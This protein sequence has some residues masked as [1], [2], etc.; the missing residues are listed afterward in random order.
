MPLHLDGKSKPGPLSIDWQRVALAHEKR[1][2]ELEAALR[3][4]ADV[5]REMRERGLD[6][7]DGN[8]INADVETAA[9]LAA[10]RLTK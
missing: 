3:P 2:A 9:Y 8:Y 6:P 4:F 7:A 5:L 1:I 10:E